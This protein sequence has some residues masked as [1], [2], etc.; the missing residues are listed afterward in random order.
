M[1]QGI[2]FLTYLYHEENVYRR[3]G[4]INTARSALSSVLPTINGQTFGKHQLVTE[5]MKG[6]FNLRPP[7][8]KYAEIW[9]P[10]KVL[11]T[12]QA[13]SPS[14]SLSLYK[15]SQKTVLLFLL[16]T[17]IRGHTLLGVRTDNMQITENKFVFYIDRSFFKQNRQGWNPD[18]VIVKKLNENKRICPYRSLKRY[19][20]RTLNI[21]G[22]HK[23]L[24][25]TTRGEHRPITRGTLRRWVVEVLQETG[26]DTTHYGSGSTRSAATSKAFAAGA[27]LDLILASGGWSRQS[28]FQQFYARPIGGRVLADY[29][30]D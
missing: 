24:F 25:L 7:Q 8:A 6:V 13:W 3:Y 15:L 1:H 16:A 2:E 11:N 10:D 14:S 27:P 17:G 28:T 29:V 26:V 21:R 20:E 9:D 30:L 5:F 19:L 4:A 23:F 18:P 12:L 22:V